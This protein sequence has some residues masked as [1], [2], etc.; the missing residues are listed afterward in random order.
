LFWGNII[1]LGLIA[2][3]YFFDIVRLDPTNYYV[4][5]A[6]VFITFSHVVLLNIGTLITCVLVLW[7]PSMIISKIAPIK[8]IKFQ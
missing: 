6:P 1:G 4:K 5:S 8:A 2:I 3:Q 7:I